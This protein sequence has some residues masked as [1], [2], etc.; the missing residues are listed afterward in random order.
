MAATIDGFGGYFLDV[1]EVDHSTTPAATTRHFRSVDGFVHS[2]LLWTD[3]SF[4]VF[5]TVSEGGLE[6]GEHAAIIAIP[7][8]ELLSGAE[9]IG[10]AVLRT[11]DEGTWGESGVEQIAISADGTQIAY[12]LNGDIWAHELSPGA[13]PR[14]LTTGPPGNVAPVF[15]PD[16]KY[17]AFVIE[18]PWGLSDTLVV[19][20][21]DGGPYLVDRSD[22]SR[23]EAYLIHERNMVDLLLTWRP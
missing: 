8:E 2:N 16:G 7:L 21:D 6:L 9:Q 1:I 14:Q 18:R 4:L 11:F 23:T 3:D 20:N 17:V 10:V 22:H 12:S 15:S 19:P 5:A 13:E